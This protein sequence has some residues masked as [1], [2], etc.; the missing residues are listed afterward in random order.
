MDFFQALT[1]SAM[2]YSL[3]EPVFDRQYRDIK[4]MDLTVADSVMALSM[5]LEDGTHHEF[6]FAVEENGKFQVIDDSDED[7][8]DN[9]G[10]VAWAKGLL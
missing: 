5:I 8:E 3:P 6:G 2:A 10:A 9:A 1:L 7:T 4:K